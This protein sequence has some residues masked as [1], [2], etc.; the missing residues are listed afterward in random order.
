MFKEQ[1]SGIGDYFL[2]SLPVEHLGQN[3]TN[4]VKLTERRPGNVN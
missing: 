2:E 4:I 1:Q 3:P